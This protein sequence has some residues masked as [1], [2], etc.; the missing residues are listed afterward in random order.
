MSFRSSEDEELCMSICLEYLIKIELPELI[1][2]VLQEEI[3]VASY[4]KVVIQFL[5][6]GHITTI[7]IEH[8]KKGASIL[9]DNLLQNL[10]M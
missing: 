6:K 8:L 7:P 10:I 1:F 2:T 3:S 5:K 9:D 4:W